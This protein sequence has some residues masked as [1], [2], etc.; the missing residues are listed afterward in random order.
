MDC[1]LTTWI[2]VS[3]FILYAESWY[4]NPYAPT[5]DTWKLYMI[6][7]GFWWKLVPITSAITLHVDKG[8]SLDNI[9]VFM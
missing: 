2:L 8:I 6:K 7:V 9:N 1:V 4:V 3:D 5:H